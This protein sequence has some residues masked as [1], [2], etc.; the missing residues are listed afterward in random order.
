MGS[1]IEHACRARR[2]RN[3]ADFLLEIMGAT[4]KAMRACEA[5]LSGWEKEEVMRLSGPDYQEALRQELLR[6]PEAAHLG[7]L[8]IIEPPGLPQPRSHAEIP[9]FAAPENR[10]EE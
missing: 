10:F 3:E 1:A 6:D 2:I 4:T 5:Q 8:D 9:S 7:W